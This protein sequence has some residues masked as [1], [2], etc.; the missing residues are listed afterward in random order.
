MLGPSVWILAGKRLEGEKFLERSGGLP[1]NDLCPTY[2]L[3]Y[4]DFAF[5]MRICIHETQL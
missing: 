5:I 4:E 1:R 2:E 3:T